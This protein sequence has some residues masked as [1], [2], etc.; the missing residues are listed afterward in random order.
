MHHQDGVT[1]ILPEVSL[2]ENMLMRYRL[3]LTPFRDP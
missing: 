2:P 1:D 3:I